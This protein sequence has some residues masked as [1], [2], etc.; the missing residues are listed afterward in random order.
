MSDLFLLSERQMA[1]IEPHFPL[2]HG[3]HASMIA[4]SSAALS[5]ST[6]MACNGR[7]RQGIT[8][9]T[10]RFIIASFVGAALACSTASSRRWPVTVPGPSAS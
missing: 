6:S 5:M 8:G 2:A 4:V 10:K 9:R 7:M 3:V 1:R